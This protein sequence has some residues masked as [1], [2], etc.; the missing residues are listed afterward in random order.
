MLSGYFN[1]FYEYA[2]LNTRG[3]ER[4]PQVYEGKGNYKYIHDFD[5]NG[6]GYFRKTSPVRMREVNSSG[7]QIKSCVGDNPLLDMV[8]PMRLVAAVPRVKLGDN[9]FSDDLL[10][11]ELIGYIG[12]KQTGIINISSITGQ[13]DS[14]Q[15]DRDKVWSDEVSGIDKTINLNLAF[16]SI[17]FTLTFR[18]NLD[19]LMQNC[20]Y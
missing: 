14:Y 2:E 13:V 4:F 19:C 5:V 18:A 15:T 11:T 7:K 1:R 17:D 20:Q 8:V 6:S 9:S 10:C 16:V 3:Q 12:K